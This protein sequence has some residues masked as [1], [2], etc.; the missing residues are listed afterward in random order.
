VYCCKQYSSAWVND[1]KDNGPY[2]NHN[3]YRLFPIDLAKKHNQTQETAEYKLLEKELYAMSPDSVH[4]S[5]GE[6][7]LYNNLVNLVSNINAKEIKINTGLGVDPVRFGNQLSKIKHIDNLEI[8]ISVE[9]GDNLYEFVRYGNTYQNFQRNL[10]T[11]IDSGLR[12]KFISVVSNMTISGIVE[13]YNQHPNTPW[14]FLL[15]NDPDYLG[16][17]VV[18]EDTKAALLIQLQNSTIPI[19]ETIIENLKTPCTEQQ[20]KNFSNYVIEFA[21][22]RNLSM[23]V[24]PSTLVQ[25][26]N[27]GKNL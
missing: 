20:H 11:V 18:D 10:Q 26:I 2:L 21:T 24:L 25:W 8:L 22:R 1:I 5:G 16:V 15:C 14:Y 4:I 7:F 27:D 23:D 13:F 12:Y 3:R 19:K 9:V 17:N 6:P